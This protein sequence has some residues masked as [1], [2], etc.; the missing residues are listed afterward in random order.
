MFSQCLSSRILCLLACLLRFGAPLFIQQGLQALR[1]FVQS[2]DLC[3]KQISLELEQFLAWISAQ[4]LHVEAT[5]TTPQCLLK[6]LHLDLTGQDRH[7]RTAGR[8]RPRELCLYL[9]K[10]ELALGDLVR[11]LFPAQPLVGPLIL[12]LGKFTLH[13]PS[14]RLRL[15][16]SLFEFRHREHGL[17]P[18]RAFRTGYEPLQLFLQFRLF[19]AGTVDQLFETGGLRLIVLRSP[20]VLQGG[21]VRGQ[22]GLALG[23]EQ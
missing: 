9:L 11:P 23:T 13:E 15:I 18:D 22:R 17:H 12:Q 4:P 2:L 5:Q 14:I 16:Q 7:I 8:T 19:S 1:T 20:Q 21:L 3:L 6:G 10:H